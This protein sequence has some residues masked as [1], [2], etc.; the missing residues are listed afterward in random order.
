[1]KMLVYYTTI[2]SI[3]RPKIF[4][5][6]L[7]YFKV[8]CHFFPFWYVGHLNIWQPYLHIS[9]TCQEVLMTVSPTRAKIGAVSIRIF[10][11]F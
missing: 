5:G 10:G 6:H 11:F 3:L 8:V 4:N 2:W 7:D 9:N 1:M